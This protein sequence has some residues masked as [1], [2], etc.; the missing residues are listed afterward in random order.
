MIKLER[1]RQNMR[2]DRLASGICSP[3]YLSKIENGT[4]IP[5]EDIE[6]MLL[7]RLNIHLDYVHQPISPSTIDHFQQQF[8][9]IINMR[10][11]QA[12]QALCQEIRS[13][14]AKY[15]HNSYTINLLLME[16][17]L[18]LMSAPVEVENNL[19]LLNSFRNDLLPNQQFHFYLIQ[20]ILTFNRNQF[21]NARHLFTK[22][23]EITKQY[24]M[25]EWELAELHYILSLTAISEHQHSLAIAYLEKAL[26][27]FNRKMLIARSV[28]CLIILGNAQKHTNHVQKALES[29]E[30][31]KEIMLAHPI[32]N[33]LGMI[34]H[35][36]G[37]CH[38]L[39]QNHEQ[40]VHHF[41]ESLS[42]KKQATSQI[43][44]VLALL[45]EHKK[46]GNLA[47]AKYFLQKG[48]KLLNL[49]NEPNQTVFNHH[50]SIYKALLYDEHDF[51]STF[52]AAIHYFNSTQNT[53]R[54][55]VYCNVL[56]D[57]LTEKN[58]FKLATTY[59]Q[60]AFQYHLAHRQIQ[61]WE[62]L[63]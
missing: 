30:S 19:K 37:S 44:T 59:Y 5:G 11:K 29:F 51:V 10:D 43:Y 1:Q 35:N 13:Y 33:R 39:L 52:D 27:Y 46:V 62:E 55:F 57:K 3:S 16:T 12:A 6:Q 54:C 8:I 15:K 9:Q 31:A 41:E 36:I 38:S 49:V 53:F 7:Q 17:R 14:L 34:E 42:I 24:K 21:S 25:S 23:E 2:Q 63:I 48:M 22:A 50:F 32:I 28:D 26:A 4:A 45:K 56:A 18:L 61:H 58:Q 20:G 47:Q 60:Q 40:A